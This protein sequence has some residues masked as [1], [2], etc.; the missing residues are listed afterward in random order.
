MKKEQPHGSGNYTWKNGVSLKSKWVRGSI[1]NGESVLTIPSKEDH[2]RKNSVSGAFI[3]GRL[4][5]PSH[6]PIYLPEIPAL[7]IAEC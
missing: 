1:S 2:L 4:V 3:D 6:P 7:D 5:S